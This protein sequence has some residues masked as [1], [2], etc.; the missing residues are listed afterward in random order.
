M[1]KQV[2]ITVAR[3]ALHSD[4][5]LHRTNKYVLA[6]PAHLVKEAMFRKVSVQASYIPSP[7][8]IDVLEVC[9]IKQWLRECIEDIH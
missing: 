3:G 9:D 2:Y 5:Q 1:S 4:G 8:V 7:K 6:L